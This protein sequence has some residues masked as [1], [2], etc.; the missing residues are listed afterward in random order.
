MNF[1]DDLR[2]GSGVTICGHAMM[3]CQHLSRLLSH[4]AV[5]TQHTKLWSL[6]SLQGFTSSGKMSR[7]RSRSDGHD[8]GHGILIVA[9]Y[10]TRE[11]KQSIPTLFHPCSPAA[12]SKVSDGD[13]AK[14]EKVD[15]LPQC[16][17]H[18]GR[19]R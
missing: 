19:L 3:L 8:L 14:Y 4:G 13:T 6:K 5:M 18:H 9:A 15:D 2:V 16:L 7:S 11:N 1:V 10:I 17:I 12:L